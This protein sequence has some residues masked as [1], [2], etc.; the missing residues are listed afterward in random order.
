MF[1]LLIININD[2]H[3]LLSRIINAGNINFLRWRSHSININVLL[4]VL[5]I[6]CSDSAIVI[7]LFYDHVL[8]DAF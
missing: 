8:H 1:C 2:G 6:N 4:D 5:A 7:F 3:V